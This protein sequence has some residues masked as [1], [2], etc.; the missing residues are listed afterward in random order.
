M[1]H[2][3]TCSLLACLTLPFS[4]IC[5]QSDP[6]TEVGRPGKLAFKEEAL[7]AVRGPGFKAEG[8][9][10]GTPLVLDEAYTAK[11]ELP[12]LLAPFKVVVPK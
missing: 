7:G 1:K 6:A 9:F 5:G 2:S 12:H 3:V 10:M 4:Q 8:V 11:H